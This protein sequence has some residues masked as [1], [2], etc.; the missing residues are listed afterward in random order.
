MLF[1]NTA[2]SKRKK[3]E[4]SGNTGKGAKTNSD[5]KKIVRSGRCRARTN[6]SSG[7][8]GG[9]RKPQQKAKREK[10]ARTSL[11]SLLL[12]LIL[13]SSLASL[14][15]TNGRQLKLDR[16]RAFKRRHFRSHVRN[17]SSGTRIDASAAQKDVDRR[18]PQRRFAPLSAKRTARRDLRPSEHSR[19]ELSPV[20]YV[21]REQQP[22][23]WRLVQ[24]G[25][26]RF[27]LFVMYNSR[28][29]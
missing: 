25:V 13:S 1:N 27:S 28:A 18:R 16:P 2:I 7:A 21:L 17:E 15:L 9:G 12:L 29:Q 8:I 3:K 22:R 26:E 23:T 14:R 11:S 5:F 10:R 4:T 19:S 24:L 20:F 6:W